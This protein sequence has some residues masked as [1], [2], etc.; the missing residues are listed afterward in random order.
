M[1][2]INRGILFPILRYCNPALKKDNRQRPR[3]KSENIAWS[4]KDQLTEEK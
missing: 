4:L 1:N 3:V 2:F